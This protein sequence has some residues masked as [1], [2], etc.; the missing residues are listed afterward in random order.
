MRGDWRPAGDA[1]NRNVPGGNP[2]MRP[3]Q[4]LQPLSRAGS[5]PAPQSQV[6]FGKLVIISSG[7]PSTGLFVYSGTPGF[8]NPPVLAI[9]AP[10]VTKDPYGNPASAVL[11]VGNLSGAHFG[12]N[13]SGDIFLVNTGGL[14]IFHGRTSDGGFFWYN[15]SGQGAGNLLAAIA[16]AAGT[17]PAGNAFKAGYSFFGTGGQ[18]IN[19]QVSGGGVPFLIFATAASEEGTAANVQA[20]I[21][22]P[23]ASEL[24]TLFVVG[25]QGSVHTDL[26]SIIMNSAAKDGS[27][28]A[29]GAL[30]YT[31]TT[32]AEHFYLEWGSKGTKVFSALV[33]D[34]N[35]YQPER[36]TQDQITAT[37]I[38]QTGFSQQILQTANL[39]VGKYVFRA[40]VDV[41]PNQAAGFIELEFAGSA[42]FSNIRVNAIETATTAAGG[43]A[44]FGNERLITALVTPFQGSTFGAADRIVDM[45]GVCTVSTAGN[46]GMFAACGTAATDTYLVH[47]SSFWEWFPIG[48]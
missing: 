4:A 28:P 21:T 38:N 43:G 20:G 25:P 32:A 16:P 27:I 2:V 29:G 36:L 13:A 15:S 9:V 30:N 48:P 8:G 39:G 17:D 19:M 10:G 3:D 34:T 42:V 11:N 46:I 45:I 1:S 33:G 6:F 18:Q 37:T 12:V 44:V 47:T 7:G 35:T 31:D 24:L 26:V 22:N 14:V 23:G 5:G 41:T 40:H